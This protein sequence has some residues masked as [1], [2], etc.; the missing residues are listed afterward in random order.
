MRGKVMALVAVVVIVAIAVA[1]VVWAVNRDDS[2]TPPASAP[3]STTATDDPTTAPTESPS[4]GTTVDPADPKW[5]AAESRPVEDSKYPNVGDPSVDALHY[6]LDLTWDPEGGR[7]TGVATIAFRATVTQD[8][9]QLDLSDALKVDGALLDGEE[10]EVSHIGK[11]LVVKA[12]VQA[13][14]RH[15][16]VVE[17]AGSPE[18]Y[19]A[20]TTRSD[21]STVGW[22]VTDTGGAWTMQEPYGAFTWYP[23][24]DQPSDKAFYDFTL[25]APAPMVGV[26]NGELT[27]RTTE[28]GMEVTAFTL[29][30]PASSYLTTV[31]FDDYVMGEGTS[32]SGVPLT[33]WTPRGDTRS[34]KAMA[35][36][37]QAFDWV[38]SKLGPYPFDR[39]GGVVVP[40][41][42]AM[43]TQTMITFGN[44]PYTLDITTLV[45]ETTHQWY[46]DAVSPTDWS[47]VW[48]NEGMTTYL[49]FI[50]ESEHGRSL[51]RV[52]R[53]AAPYESMH[54]AES[55]PP[56]DYDP[57]AF[58]QTNIYYGPA[59]MW[60]QVRE[61]IG[62]D[63]FWEMV[64]AWPTVHRFGNASRDTYLAWVEKQTGADLK[65]L[66]DAW[67][68][69]KKSPKLG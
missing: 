47:D 57:R 31:A 1:G 69:G 60:H 35:K 29:S 25:R 65:D 45:H 5:K 6:G 52:L 53:E 10:V 12:P 39:L 33:W 38:E 37:P 56:G 59:L 24:N 15:V 11:D 41:Q 3:P 20:P 49:D 4:I 42:T 54:R 66:F 63:K 50:W 28:A 19:P 64:R 32:S 30:S 18:S 61:R 68:L 40:S 46:G 16:L 55:G 58:G 21:L 2:K 26:A 7:L 36:L 8:L 67:L 17:Y 51:D 9:F 23:V 22:T 13:D 44:T 14:S 27:S 34:A 43:E 48:M 62:D